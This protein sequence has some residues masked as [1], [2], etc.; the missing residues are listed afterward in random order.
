[1]AWHGVMCVCV[2]VFCTRVTTTSRHVPST[3][4]RANFVGKI[5]KLA[6]TTELS[7]HS[8]LL[9]RNLFLLKKCNFFLVRKLQS[10]TVSN[11][12]GSIF[13]ND[14]DCETYWCKS[15][16]IELMLVLHESIVQY[17]FS[18]CRIFLQSAK[19]ASSIA[20]NGML[21]TIN[22]WIGDFNTVSSCRDNNPRNKNN[23]KR[24]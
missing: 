3:K 15:M 19:V 7:A 1:M 2:S 6:P 21:I 5:S 14:C 18:L 8:T 9:W 24:N 11:C 16:F 10:T 17:I 23:N 20:S 12:K 4:P 13:K 22:Q